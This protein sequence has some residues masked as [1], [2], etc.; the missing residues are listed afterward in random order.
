M[1]GQLPQQPIVTLPQLRHAFITR[2]EDVNLN[3]YLVTFL[4]LSYFILHLLPRRLRLLNLLP[5]RRQ[6]NTKVLHLFVLLIDLLVKTVQL[7]LLLRQE[8]VDDL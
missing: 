7:L 1:L 3:V 6:I 2:L 8:L 5:E 4:Q